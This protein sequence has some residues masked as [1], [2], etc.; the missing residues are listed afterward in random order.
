MEKRKFSFWRLVKIISVVFGILVILVL[1]TGWYLNQHWNKLLRKELSGYVT[2][3]S[4]SLYTVRFSDLK[5]D[6]LSGSVTVTNASMAL[7]SAIYKKLLA[8]HR[9]PTDI[10]LVSVEKLQLRYFKP[11][12]YFNGKELNAGSLTVT[13]PSIIM[14]QNAT[15]K[16]TTKPKTAYENISSKMKSIF[17]GKLVLDGTN[18]KYIF[19]RKDSSKVIHQFHNLRVR[20]ND[21]LIDSVAINDP[22]RFLY[23]RN[24]EIGMKDYMHRTRD[25]LYWMNVR[26]ISY[27]AAERAL[28]IEQ[29]SIEPRYDKEAFQKKVGVQQDRYDLSFN[30]ISIHE[31]DPR[32][33]LQEQQVWAQ[34]INIGSGKLDIYRNRN[35]PMPPGNKLGQYPNQQLQKLK[36]PI[37]IDT[38]TGNNVEIQYAELSNETQQ[39]GIIHFNHVHGNFR[40][41]TNIDSLIA[42]NNHC[43]A[44]LDAIFMQSGKLKARFDF[45]LNS[46]P[47]QFAVS[48][49]LQNMNG[50]D[51]N[52]VTKPLGKVEIRSCDIQD[53]TFVIKGDERKAAGHV[54]LLYKNLKIAVLK[55]DKDHQ[56]FTRKGLVSFVANL[57]VIKDSNPLK[58]EKVRTSDPVYPRDIKKSFFNLVWKTLFTGVKETAG[59]KNI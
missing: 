26:G 28:N 32:L 20:V 41:I 1:C 8:Q 44:D 24:Y 48:G 12:R 58:D 27:D 15:V 50:K 9:A 46:K 49:Q 47:G 13:G 43:V 3:L 7:D 29:F 51:L 42:K 59:A 35:L 56:G 23:A 31:L 10:Y 36:L 18:F 4:D 37:K 54:K 11:W 14:E 16:D 5:L 55:Q 25:S 19:T 45:T 17:I 34:R 38:L 40:N 33:L 57:L 6:V 53:L 52:V 21:F 30:N 39:T 2:D 22:T